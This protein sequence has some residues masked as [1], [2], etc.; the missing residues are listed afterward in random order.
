MRRVVGDPFKSC[1]LIYVAGRGGWQHIW[2]FE[3]EVA[4]LRRLDHP[5]IVQLHESFQ[6]TERFLYVMELANI[7]S[8]ADPR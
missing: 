2:E 8:L 7:G 3:N 5:N 1:A 4:L 6:A